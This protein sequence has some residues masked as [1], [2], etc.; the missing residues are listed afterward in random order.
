MNTTERRQAG[1]YIAGI[2]LVATVAVGGAVTI[3]WIATT[4]LSYSYE[5]VVELFF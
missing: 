3:W 2:L 1:G 5:K 4:Y